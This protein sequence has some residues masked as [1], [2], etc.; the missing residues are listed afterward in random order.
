MVPLLDITRLMSRAGRTLTGV[1][2]VEL[3]YLDQFLGAAQ[4]FGLARTGLGFLLLDHRGLSRFRQRLDSGDWGRIDGLSRWSRRLDPLQKAAVSSVRRDAIARARPRGLAKMVRT[5]GAS[6]YFNIGHANLEAATLRAIGA[7]GLKRHVFLHDTIP[8]DHPQWQRPGTVERFRQKFDAAIAGSDRIICNSAAT[9]ADVERLATGLVPP[10]TVAH[11]GVTLPAAGERHP[12]TPDGPY[13]VTIG[14]IEP[15]KNHALLLDVWD[16]LADQPDGPTLVICGPR[17][18]NNADVFARLDANMSDRVKEASGLTD[19]QLATL[20][21]SGQGL[22][23]PS[24]AEGYGLPPLEAAG[25]RVPVVC[26]DLAI[27]RETLGNIPIYLD[28]TE[29]YQWVKVINELV[30]QP[31]APEPFA[32]PTWEAHFKTVLNMA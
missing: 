8:L 20:L 10:I 5:S 4:A 13:F 15:R 7:A 23:F 28:P 19:A 18:W 14:T 31:P 29:P 11:L 9:A 26:G 32:P 16:R 27:Y 24:L 25:L 22:L 30:E 1:D 2:R 17:G 21:M 12:I 6:D 3:A